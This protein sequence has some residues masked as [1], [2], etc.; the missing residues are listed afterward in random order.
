[1]KELKSLITKVAEG[2]QAMEKTITKKFDDFKDEIVKSLLNVSAKTD[3]LNLKVNRIEA[4]VD[5]FVDDESRIR[6][7]IL[8]GI[9]TKDGEDLSKIFN[10]LVSNLG[11]EFEPEA[12]LY[13]FKGES[14]TR[15]IIIKFPTEF[16]KEDFM[17]RYFKVANTLVLSKISGFR[18]GEKARIFIQHDFALDQYKMNKAA[19]KLRASGC[20]KAIRIT[21][22]KVG[23]KF[24]NN[25]PFVYFNS[26][27]ALEK[28]AKKHKQA[29]YVETKSNMI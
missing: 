16:H 9:P 15:P 8:N 6:N 22:G 27:D 24:V 7:L 20:L 17:Q 2:Q 21:H 12:K 26:I 25:G 29:N 10:S 3:Q 4:K 1:M 5:R 23:V 13:R 28:E 14:E 18:K 11:Y 19:V